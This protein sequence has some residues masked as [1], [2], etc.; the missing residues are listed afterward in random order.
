MDTFK[1]DLVLFCF[2][3]FYTLSLPFII[4]V[5]MSPGDFLNYARS[6]GCVHEMSDNENMYKLTNKLGGKCYVFARYKRLYHRTAVL[7]CID[8]GIPIISEQEYN[9]YE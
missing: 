3:H 8:L 7:Y 2:N 4:F 1:I 5:Q 6:K 9:S